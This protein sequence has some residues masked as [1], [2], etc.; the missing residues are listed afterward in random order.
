MNLK[1]LVNKWNTKYLILALFGGCISI[2]GYLIYA[3]DPIQILIDKLL[4]LQPGSI[5]Y[6]LWTFPP[7]EI[8]VNV[9][10]FNITNSGRFLAG[11][12][13]LNVTEVGPY[14]YQEILKNTN[15]H[16]N[17]NNTLT[18]KPKRELV[19][20]KDLSPNNPYEDLI[21]TPNIPLLGISSYLKD[22][23]GYVINLGLAS[24]ANMV[25]SKPIEHL[26]PSSYLFGYD[27][28]LV[29]LASTY[30]PSWIDFTKFGILDRIM[31]LDNADNTVT[32][33][34][35]NSTLNYSNSD[36]DE[37]LPNSIN[38]FNG[39]PGLKHLGY[40]DDEKSR[41]NTIQGA[42]DGGLFARNMKENT[43]LKLYRRA[44][45]RTVNI[46]YENKNFTNGGLEYYQYRLDPN[47][48]LNNISDNKCYCSN[49]KKCLPN[50]FGSIAPCY[51]GI[52]IV[53]SQPHYYNADERVLEQV[54]GL[55]PTKEKHDTIMKIN[56]YLGVPIEGKLRVQINLKVS[57]NLAVS[58]YKPFQGMMLPL[59]WLEMVIDDTPF[60]IKIVMYIGK[61]ITSIVI[62]ISCVLILLGM[63]LLT[64]AMLFIFYYPCRNHNL[65]N[66]CDNRVG[67]SPILTVP[68]QS[69]RI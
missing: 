66:L 10:I 55:N 37:I 31:A 60:Y 14:V 1:V 20:R 9:Y 50:G 43:T 27:D 30:I 3:L 13:K 16:L 17:K 28:P 42:F 21:I 19:F 39:S 36:I 23:Y 6:K 59:F 65:K 22:N 54:N 38:I 52:P 26:T 61:Y 24:V 25:K 47:L 41:C 64:L 44:F 11:K 56:P 51:Y 69:C 49:N 63:S 2:L 46:V 32:L 34:L 57:E 68:M 12:E 15:G 48:L 40:S 18:Y 4:T 5:L 67:Y 58:N 33:H 45:C 29:T 8:L 35:S 62:T 7:Y 53:I